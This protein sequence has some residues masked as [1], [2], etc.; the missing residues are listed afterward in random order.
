MKG[1]VGLVG[2]PVADGLPTLVVTHQLQVEHRTGKVHQSETDV[3]PL[4]HATNQQYVRQTLS[5]VGNRK[6]YCCRTTTKAGVSEQMLF[7]WLTLVV[8]DRRPLNGILLFFN[9]TNFVELLHIRPH[10]P[11]VMESVG[12]LDQIFTEASNIKRKE[13]LNQ[14]PCREWWS[15]PISI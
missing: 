6:S 2:W 8:L 5:T 11:K 9:Q 13:I 3:L 12:F 10:L 7:L 14:K 4:C 1:W 15:M